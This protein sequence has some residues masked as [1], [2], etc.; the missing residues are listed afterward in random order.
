MLGLVGYYRCC[1]HNISSAATFQQLQSALTLAPVRWNL[2]FNLSYLVQT[3][4]GIGAV[5]S[6]VFGDKENP[7]LYISHKLTPSEQCYAAMKREA[8]AIK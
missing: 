3:E 1:V 6:Q 2:D 8:L 7:I 4:M 5:L